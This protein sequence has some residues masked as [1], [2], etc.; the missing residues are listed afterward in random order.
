MI[1]VELRPLAAFKKL[2]PEAD[3]DKGSALI[4]APA[5]VT[6]AGFLEQAGVGQ[7]R[8]LVTLVNGR[9]A[10]LDSELKDGDV[11]AVFPPVAGG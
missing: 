3:R 10:A 1:R 9:H 4:E 2:L 7:G 5:G 11:V 8:T 6:L